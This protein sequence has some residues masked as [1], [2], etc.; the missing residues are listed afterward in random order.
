MR[1]AIGSFLGIVHRLK[2]QLLL[3]AGGFDLGDLRDLQGEGPEPPRSP[4]AKTLRILQGRGEPLEEY[5]QRWVRP[6]KETWMVQAA[7]DGLVELVQWHD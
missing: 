2:C 7:R 5:I 4:A 1:T 6:G 3:G